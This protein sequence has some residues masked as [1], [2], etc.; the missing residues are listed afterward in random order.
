MPYEQEPAELAHY[1][2]ATVDILYKFP[3][4]LEELE[5]VANRTDYDL[6]S[7]SKNQDSLGLTASV[8]KNTDSTAKLTILDL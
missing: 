2:K 4:G 5:G 8:T 6:G 3:H 7:H 1:A